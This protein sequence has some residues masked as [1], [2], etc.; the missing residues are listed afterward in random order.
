MSNTAI[1]QIGDNSGES[2]DKYAPYRNR[3]SDIVEAANVWLKKVTEITDEPTAKAC[4]DFLAQIAGELKAI[5]A[6]R[7]AWNKPHDDAIAANNNTFKPMTL[8]LD[9]AKMLLSPLK[10]KWLQ[11]EKDR[12]AQERA[13]K[14][15]AA[16]KA[17]Q[18]AEDAARKATT[19]VEAAVRADE[20][21]ERAQEAL[22]A[23]AAADKAKASVKGDVVR[24]SG[25]RTYWSATV[26]DWNA[27]AQ[28]YCNTP[29]VQAA[30]QVAANANAREQKAAMKVPGCKA[31]SEERA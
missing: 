21:Q 13:A 30:I 12:L 5:D 31:I 17:M 4:D 1:A 2:A 24:A 29:A 15:A 23:S 8:L 16:L 14:E 6:D 11:R 20:A 25:L 3:T 27:A 28:H 19:S 26:E 10:V 22:D 18:E 7:K 9:K